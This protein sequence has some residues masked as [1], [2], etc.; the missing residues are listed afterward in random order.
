MRIGRGGYNPWAAKMQAEQKRVAEEQEKAEHGEQPPA[1]GHGGGG[2]GVFEELKNVPTRQQ[3]NIS[4]ENESGLS[5][6]SGGVNME[7]QSEQGD[8]TPEMFDENGE[9]IKTVEQV[10]SALVQHREDGLDGMTSEE[11]EREKEIE[12]LLGKKQEAVPQG[13]GIQGRSSQVNVN[14]P[15]KPR[16]SYWDKKPDQE[17]KAFDKK[18][19]WDNISKKTGS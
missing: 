6:E 12:R 3:E 13:M 15:P 17:E 19:F 9:P 2:Y 7:N 18:S 4:T 5:V 8:G 16:S 14:T 1:A 10:N 11:H